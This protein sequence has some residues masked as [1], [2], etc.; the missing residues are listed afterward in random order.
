[1]MDAVRD[2]AAESRYELEVD[3]QIVF[4]HY[5]RREGTLVIPYVEAPP[6]LRGTGAAGRLMQGVAEIARAEGLKIVPLCSYAAA[7]MRRHPEHRD[8]LG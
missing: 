8:L 4:A 6:A 7:W 3:G 5:R 1:M 2:N